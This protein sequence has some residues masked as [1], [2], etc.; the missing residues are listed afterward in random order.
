M[1]DGEGGMFQALSQMDGKTCVGFIAMFVAVNWLCNRFMV[2][3]RVATPVPP[4]PR[5]RS[6]RRASRT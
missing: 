1:S 3:A 6:S 5:R 2:R 4:P